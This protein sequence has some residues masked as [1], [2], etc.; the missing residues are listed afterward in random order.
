MQAVISRY[1][2]TQERIPSIYQR[3]PKA[4]I[5]TSVTNQIKD[6]LELAK[7]GKVAGSG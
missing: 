2:R 6:M 4:A 3:P 1:H 5:A 7:L